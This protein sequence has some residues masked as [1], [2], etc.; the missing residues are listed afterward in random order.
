VF[1]EKKVYSVAHRV[2]EK[3]DFHVRAVGRCCHRTL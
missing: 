2:V 1:G 3:Q